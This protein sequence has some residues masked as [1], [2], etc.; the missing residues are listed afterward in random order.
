MLMV[1]GIP[2]SIGTGPKDQNT[3]LFIEDTLY[4]C[5][6]HNKVIALQ[7]ENGKSDGIMLLKLPH[8]IGRVV[9]N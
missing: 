9:E 7:L 2:A 4:I 5:T 1:G 6:S 3:P 8:Q